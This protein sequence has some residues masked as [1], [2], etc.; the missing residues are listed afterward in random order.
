MR[1]VLLSLSVW[2][3]LR[4]GP[5]CSPPHKALYHSI[6]DRPPDSFHYACL[7]LPLFKRD[8]TRHYFGASASP[9]LGRVMSMKRSTTLVGQL[10]CRLNYDLF[11]L[12]L[13]LDILSHASFERA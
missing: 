5:E 11:L 1:P 13:A 7:A 10:R 3:P 4:V 6:P 12:H 2:I 9:F 8:R